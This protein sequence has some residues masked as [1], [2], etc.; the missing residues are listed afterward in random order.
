MVLERK[1]SGRVP[2][3]PAH[4]AELFGLQDREDE[5]DLKKQNAGF[6]E[7]KVTGIFRTEYQRR[8]A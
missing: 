1:A 4:P 5:P 3:S 2:L 8:G 6:G 7:P